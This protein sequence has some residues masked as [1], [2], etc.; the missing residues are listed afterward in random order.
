MA[1]LRLCQSLVWFRC[2]LS[3]YGHCLSSFVRL[4]AERAISTFM[5][6]SVKNTK[7]AALVI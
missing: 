7:V 1:L 5:A 3:L 2:S 6:R 4:E